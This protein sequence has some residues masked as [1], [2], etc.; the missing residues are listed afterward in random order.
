MFVQAWS[1]AIVAAV[2]DSCWCSSSSST[3]WSSSSSAG[4]VGIHYNLSPVSQPIR[5]RQVTVS[6]SE[7]GRSRGA[8]TSLAFQIAWPCTLPHKMTHLMHIWLVD[9]FDCAC[10]CPPFL[11]LSPFGSAPPPCL[12]LCFAYN[13]KT[14]RVQ[15]QNWRRWS[16]HCVSHTHAHACTHTHKHTWRIWVRLWVLISVF[17]RHLWSLF[18]SVCQAF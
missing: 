11:R 6:Q 2:V 7:R 5:Q 17:V 15:S 16:S 1:V 8:S 10:S 13:L 3:S 12:R 4:D 14:P 9:T 18:L